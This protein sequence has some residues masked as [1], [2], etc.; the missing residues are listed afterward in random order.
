M[1][2]I[3]T[4]LKKR[5]RHQFI[6]KELRRLLS[7]L[8]IPHAELSILIVGDSKMRSLNRRFRGIDR[9]TDVLSFPQ[10][11]RRPASYKAVPLLLGDIVIN[12]HQI[13]RQAIENNVPF[14]RELRHILIHGL[15]HLLGYDHE[16]SDPERVKMERREEKLL[17]ALERMDHKR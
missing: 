9:T 14:K 16:R 4:T 11:D 8:K 1:I 3:K 15:L 12:P 2:L 7:L 13:K 6:K 10:I 17:Y 5:V